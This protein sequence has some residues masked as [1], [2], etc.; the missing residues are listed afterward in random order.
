M[1]STRG[2]PSEH[3]PLERAPRGRVVVR[4]LIRTTQY[5]QAITQHASPTGSASREHASQTSYGCAS[6]HTRSATAAPARACRCAGSLWWSGRTGAGTRSTPS[7]PCL[8]SRSR[9]RGPPAASREGPPSEAAQGVVSLS[10]AEFSRRSWEMRQS[11]MARRSICT[12]LTG[13]L[14]RD[15][16]YS[17]CTPW[18]STIPGARDRWPE[19]LEERKNDEDGR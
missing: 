17:D 5:E 14:R 10:S 2:A 11:D 7:T 8:C 18:V 12:C 9:A 1:C 15:P 16:I 19:G 4:A 13:S 3:Y 6:P